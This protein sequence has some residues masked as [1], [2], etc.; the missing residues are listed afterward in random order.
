MLSAT[1]T[2]SQQTRQNCLDVC[3]AHDNPIFNNFA[4]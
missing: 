1:E 4:D 3:A 2:W